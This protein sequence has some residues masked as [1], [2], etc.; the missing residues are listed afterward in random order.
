M[1]T[2]LP[3]VNKTIV[4]K[5]KFF[6]MFIYFWE[7]ERARAGEGK[8]ETETQILKQAP[9]SEL[10]AQ[11]PTWAWTHE[12]WDHDPSQSRTLNRLSHPSAPVASSWQNSKHLLL[13]LLSGFGLF[14]HPIPGLLPCYSAEN[15]TSQGY[16][17]LYLAKSSSFF[18]IYLTLQH[19]MQLSTFPSLKYVGYPH[20]SVVWLVSESR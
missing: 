5:K 19:L 3:K 11:S 7:T 4:F 12:P 8:R 10:S 14:L 1:S 6:L 13:Y 15:S 16:Q 9:G 17:R 20:S 2:P 18:L